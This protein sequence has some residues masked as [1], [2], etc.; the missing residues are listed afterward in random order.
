[1]QFEADEEFIAKDPFRFGKI[2]KRLVTVN[3]SRMPF[4]FSTAVRMKGD[5]PFQ[6]TAGR[7]E[8][9]SAAATTENL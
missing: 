6:R 1:M 3:V 8:K 2:I 7:K 4:V 5:L 9:I